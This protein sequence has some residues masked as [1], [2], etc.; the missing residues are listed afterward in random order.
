MDSKNQRSKPLL[1]ELF[2]EGR[3]DVER[4]SVYLKEIVCY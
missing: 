4:N 2:Q 1:T 3:D